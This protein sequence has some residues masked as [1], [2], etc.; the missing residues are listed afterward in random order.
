MKRSKTAKNA[1]SLHH[2]MYGRRC[3][4]REW[5]K[6]QSLKQVIQRINTMPLPKRQSG[7]I[8]DNGRQEST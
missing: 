5:F 3:R 1:I 6:G 8:S 7:T 4:E 2:E